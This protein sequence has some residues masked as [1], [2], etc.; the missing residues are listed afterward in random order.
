MRD[1]TAFYYT[2]L[3]SSDQCVEVEIKERVLDLGPLRFLEVKWQFSDL[4]SPKKRSVC[5]FFMRILLCEF[6]QVKQIPLKLSVS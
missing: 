2:L 3:L 6:I 4:I 1:P 5:L